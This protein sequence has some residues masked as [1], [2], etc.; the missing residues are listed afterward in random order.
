M[1]MDVGGLFASFLVS[2]IGFVLFSY[3]RKMSRAPQVASGLVLMIF[4]YFV[5]NLW[6]E[7]SITLA[8]LGGLY[9]ALRLGW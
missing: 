9:V 7:A 5:S 3:G 1:D 8:I 4:P 2:G 6:L